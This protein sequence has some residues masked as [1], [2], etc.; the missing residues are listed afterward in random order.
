MA[1]K[2]NPDSETAGLDSRSITT[3]LAP[4]QVEREALLLAEGSYVL[5]F[6]CEPLATDGMSP[7]ELETLARRAQAFLHAMPEGEDLRIVYEVASDPGGTLRD[8]AECTENITGT[9]RPWRDLR[10]RTHLRNQRLGTTLRARLL[11]FLTYHPPRLHP[12]SRWAV[13]TIV[14]G[15]VGVLA[16]ALFGWRWGI[17]GAGVLWAGLFF[18]MPRRP[19]RFAAR[20]QRQFERD[21]RTLAGM[22]AVAIA[23]L[24]AMGLQPQ[25]LAPEEYLDAVWRYLNPRQ[26]AGTVVPPEIPGH[27]YELSRSETAAAPWALPVSFRQVAARTGLDRDW[28]HLRVDDRF[29]KVFAMDGLPVGTTVMLHLLPLLGMREPLTCVFDI[30]KPFSHP[31]IQR[32]TARSSLAS[33]VA[34]SAA[35]EAATVGAA[36]QH[37]SLMQILSRVFGGEIQVVRV[38][39]GIVVARRSLEQLDRTAV[40]LFRLAGEM[41]ALTLVD[42]TLALAPQF[43]RLLPASGKTNRRM[44]IATSENAV[45]LMPLSGPWPGSPRVEAVFPNRWGGLTAIDLFDRRIAGWNG[46]VAG[47]TGTGKSAFVCQLLMQLLRPTVRAIVI[48]KGQNVPPGSYL[49]LARALGGAEIRFDVGGGT[50]INPFDIAPEQLGYFLGEE[51]SP[52]D[53]Q[54]A[55]QKHTFLVTLVDRLVSRRGGPGLSLDEQALV[56]E[57]IVQMYRRQHLRGEPAFLRDLV[58]TLRNPGGVGGHALTPEQGRAMDS[59]ATRLWHWCDRGRY[60]LLL[61]RPTNVTLD[62]LMTYIDIG[63][64]TSQPELM[65]VVVLLLQD[66]IYRQAL[67]GVGRERLIVVQDELWSVLADPTA[68]RFLDDMYRRFRHV[69]AAVLSVSQDIRDFQSPE[70]RAILGNAAWWFLLPVVDTNSTVEVAGLNPNQARLLRKLTNRPGEHAEILALV[71]LGDRT[72]CGVLVARPTSA[73]FWVAASNPDERALRERYVRQADGDVLAALERLARDH[74]RGCDVLQGGITA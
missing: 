61:D 4:W 63:P 72:E 5:G 24:G 40:E 32:L 44:R 37:Q 26:A 60:A 15:L 45:H 33:N 53:A 46:V 23:H 27:V 14:A 41:R 50:S 7:Q 74:P 59:I 71:R 10:L 3:E 43:R 34:E 69:G 66:L 36:R 51:V 21:H 54:H 42:E 1:L 47:K 25:A 16:S 64:I 6:R 9:L 35:S 30:H 65:P 56:G 13:S 70:A 17:L 28:G 52:D 73:E 22:R 8:H 12:P 18:L 57:A 31:M 68:A 39:L 11:I 19:G 58:A 55:A 29:V 62:G 2:T 20:L 49:T 38:G 48:D 67:R